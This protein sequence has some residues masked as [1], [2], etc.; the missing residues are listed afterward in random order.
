[1]A[2]F[3]LY[4]RVPVLLLSALLAA[5]SAS[6]QQIAE[7]VRDRKFEIAYWAAAGAASAAVAFDAYTTLSSIGPG[8]RCNVE[9]ES[10]ALYGRVPT[11][12]RTVAVMGSQL[13]AA[14]LLSRKLQ[15]RARGKAAR[16]LTLLLAASNAVHF[17][18]AIHNERLCR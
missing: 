12:A 2:S 15:R 4:A 1:M 10:P 6:A 17:A 11:P 8:K 16:S 13:G 14:I 18:G 7:P 5:E 9:V 3:R